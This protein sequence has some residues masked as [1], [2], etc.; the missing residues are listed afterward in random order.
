MLERAAA[1]QT[2]QA[3]VENVVN[4]LDGQVSAGHI[5]ELLPVGTK[6]EAVNY[7]LW[8]AAQTNR[9]QRISQGVYAPL[10]S[11]KAS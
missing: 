9:I 3:Q 4:A 6:R 10:T 8:R 1:A 5:L 11:A 7:A 2:I